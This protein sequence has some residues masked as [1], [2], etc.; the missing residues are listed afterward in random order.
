[1]DG[2]NLV[3]TTEVG[4]AYAKQFG[5][6]GDNAP[7]EGNDGGQT[8]RNGWEGESKE[9]SNGQFTEAEATGS[10]KGDEAKVPGD[11]T[12]TDADG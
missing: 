9:N 1:M 11:G 2:T 7:E 5:G 12:D 4:D 3:A 8:G 10:D 6:G